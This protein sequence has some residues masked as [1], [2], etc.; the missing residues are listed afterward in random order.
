MFRLILLR[1]YISFLAFLSIP[2]YLSHFLFKPISWFALIPQEFNHPLSLLFLVLLFLQ[3]P[4]LLIFQSLFQI[5]LLS[6]IFLLSCFTFLC[7]S[8]HSD[9]GPF[10]PEEEDWLLCDSD[11]HAL[12][13]DCHFVPSLFLA[14]PGIC[15]RKDR[16]RL[17]LP[18]TIEI[19]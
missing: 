15:P 3:H 19:L 4:L 16:V 18:S 10:L 14:E 1:H 8:I 5:P 6:L 7:R 9:D 11:L 17:V 13:H 2:L 12:L